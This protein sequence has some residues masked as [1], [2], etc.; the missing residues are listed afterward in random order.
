ML[1]LVATIGL[2]GVELV[3]VVGVRSSRRGFEGFHEVG[4]EIIVG[5]VVVGW[6]G[7]GALFAFLHGGSD[8]LGGPFDGTAGGVV[9]GTFVSFALG[10]CCAFCG[11]SC[12]NFGAAIAT[13]VMVLAWMI[14]SIHA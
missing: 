10:A 2:V 8:A 9:T 1:D 12:F 6:C 5:I 13:L 3:V 11:F 4:F 7:D 14:P